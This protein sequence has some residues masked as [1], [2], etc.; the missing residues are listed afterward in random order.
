MGT[1]S[2]KQHSPLSRSPNRGATVRQ[3]P[4]KSP[5]DRFAAVAE[6][7]AKKTSSALPGQR[8]NPYR[9]VA[10]DLSP[11]IARLEPNILKLF[12]KDH[13]EADERSGE[14]Q[15]IP[16]KPLV[17]P[18]SLSQM[19]L[20]E[21]KC[22]LQ[23]I[24]DD[25]ASPPRC[26]D[27]T[28]SMS[29]V[30]PSESKDNQLN[31]I[32][33]ML[34]ITN[35]MLN[36]SPETLVLQD[37][38]SQDRLSQEL[39][40]EAHAMQKSP[41]VKSPPRPQTTTSGLLEQPS[42]P[43]LA[44]EILPVKYYIMG[45]FTLPRLSFIQRGMSP[46]EYDRESRYLVSLLCQQQCVSHFISYDTMSCYSIRC[47]HTNLPHSTIVALDSLKR[48]VALSYLKRKYRQ[49]FNL[50]PLLLD[51]LNGGIFNEEQLSDP[52]DIWCKE[53]FTRLPKDQQRQVCNKIRLKVGLIVNHINNN[54]V[55]P[56]FCDDN[57]SLDCLINIAEKRSEEI[58]EHIEK[59]L[60]NITSQ[61]FTR[62]LSKSDGFEQLRRDRYTNDIMV[63]IV[64]MHFSLMSD[65][66][67]GTRTFCASPFMF[68]GLH[69]SIALTFYRN[70]DSRSR[71]LLVS[72]EQPMGYSRLWLIDM[73]IFPVCCNSHW[74]VYIY[75]GKLSKLSDTLTK[76][77]GGG[78]KETGR[79]TLVWMDSILQCNSMLNHPVDESYNLQI[80]QHMN[81]LYRRLSPESSTKD[82]PSKP[83]T[84]KSV[85][86][87]HICQQRD[88]YS[89]AYHMFVIVF[90]LLSMVQ[91]GYKLPDNM[92]PDQLA[93]GN[94]TDLYPQT[95]VNAMKY[96]V[97][98]YLIN[99]SMYEEAQD[100]TIDLPRVSKRVSLGHKLEKSESSSSSVH[101]VTAE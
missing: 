24:N 91:D 43:N 10:K 85:V 28:Q 66:F 61:S 16:K 27:S 94:W 29:I 64:M 93:S 30:T 83:F 45:P 13:P 86:S 81:A 5:K 89:C 39:L 49:Y 19:G 50:S 48:I 18:C 74:S 80:I 55:I 20:S 36:T 52:K 11:I 56:Q 53:A 78:S 17:T 76:L 6:P 100:N 98:Q 71:D 70:V 8:P 60:S 95:S 92:T 99:N 15:H 25:M 32:Q 44:A 82:P 84:R 9:A 96:W 12:S 63:D 77:C 42:F 37:Q 72:H 33:S 101:I 4:N 88:Q 87:L 65:A 2:P 69:N 47:S 67:Y 97:L 3:S 51:I 75:I 22:P 40:R 41:S 90:S 23:R 46:A 58:D 57:I 73:I 14:A 26:F 34:A 59:L 7:M 62:S 35:I 68:L 54:C 38:S 1:P 79:S 31:Q 21:S